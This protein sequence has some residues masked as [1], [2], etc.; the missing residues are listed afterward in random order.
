MEVDLITL[1]FNDVKVFPNCAQGPS[2]T[3]KIIT[4]GDDDDNRG[5]GM[6]RDCARVRTAVTQYS[7][8]ARLPCLRRSDRRTDPGIW[9]SVDLVMSVNK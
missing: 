4:T 7:L 6:H 3:L 2:I 8:V 5:T 9:M 1:M